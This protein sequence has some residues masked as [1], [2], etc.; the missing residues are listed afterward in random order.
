MIEK[1]VVQAV[2]SYLERRGWKVTLGHIYG[3][4]TDVVAVKEGSKYL[5]QAKG[6]RPAHESYQIQHAL[7]EIV[8]IMREENPEIRYGIALTERV[9]KHLWKFGIVGLKALNL[10]LFVVD[11][12]GWV[13]HLAPEAVFKH[14]KEC[15]ERGESNFLTFSTPP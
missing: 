5:I 15:M 6:D 7:G 10:H 12:R 1:E 14:G 11:D 4:E 8:A 13:W 3:F 9:A 2:R